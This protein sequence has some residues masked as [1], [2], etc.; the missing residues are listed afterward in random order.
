[1][2]TVALTEEDDDFR[3]LVPNAEAIDVSPPPT[4]DVSQICCDDSS[5]KKPNLS[6]PT[7]NNDVT[8]SADKTPDTA[9]SCKCRVQPINDF[10]P[11]MAYSSIYGFTPVDTSRVVSQPDPNDGNITAKDIKY[12]KIFSFCSVALFPPTAIACIVLTFLS[13]KELTAGLRSHQ[14]SLI[15]KAT[16]KAK[17]CERLLVLSLIFGVITY[18]LIFAIVEKTSE[19]GGVSHFW[20]AQGRTA[21]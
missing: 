21:G 15:H 2:A 6:V 4:I 9:E 16:K 10:A 13:E 19:S 14:Q 11:E 8:S 3:E 18:V 5:A 17:I 12:L 7:D 1:M 20:T